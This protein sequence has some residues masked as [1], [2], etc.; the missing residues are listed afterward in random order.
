MIQRILVS[1][2]GCR[3]TFVIPRMTVKITWVTVCRGFVTWW[4]LSPCWLLK[5]LL[6]AVFQPIWIIF[7]FLKM[8][9]TC[10]T[11][12][13]WSFLG[14]F[15]FHSLI[16]ASWNA[17]TFCGWMQKPPFLRTFC[18]CLWDV[19]LSFWKPP[20][21]V[22]QVFVNLS[23]SYVVDCAVFLTS[24]SLPNPHIFCHVT[25]QLSL[26]VAHISAV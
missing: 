4:V 9:Y 21:F 10:P 22:R 17:N 23:F 8:A 13:S 18:Y 7:H 14:L 16:S 2:I 12:C 26:E 19:I 3:S 25:L 6:V 15:S 24:A 5:L 20:S 11:L 1:T